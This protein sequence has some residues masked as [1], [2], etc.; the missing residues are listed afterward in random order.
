MATDLVHT[1]GFTDRSSSDFTI[2]DGIKRVLEP[3]ASLKLT[4]VLFALS[5]VLILAGTFAQVD[6]DIWEVIGLY[7]RCWFAWVPFQVFFPA[8]FFHL[9]PRGKDAGVTAGGESGFGTS[10][11]LQSGGHRIS[12]GGGFRQYR[13]GLR[14]ELGDHRGRGK[15]QRHHVRTDDSLQHAM[16]W[17]SGTARSGGVSGRVW[18]G[19]SRSTTSLKVR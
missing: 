9:V 8:S 1:G 16:D 6:K 13:P 14:N 11:P 17:L 12:F 19:D 5:I 15:L 4:V 10:D 7:F 2:W 18:I 3:A